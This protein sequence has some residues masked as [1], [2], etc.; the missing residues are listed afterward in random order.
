MRCIHI[1]DKLTNLSLVY[2]NK[3]ALEQT[4]EVSDQ[5]STIPAFFFFPDMSFTGGYIASWPITSSHRDTVELVPFV[6]QAS[7]FL[8]QSPL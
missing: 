3:F 2:D 5:G 4:L 8:L 7:H 6:S 1:S